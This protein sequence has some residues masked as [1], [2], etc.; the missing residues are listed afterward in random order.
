LAR[1][2]WKPQANEVFAVIRSEAAERLKKAGAVFYEWDAPAGLDL[3][4]DERL[5]RFVTS[6][7]TTQQDVDRFA[8][9]I[10]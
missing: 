4:A 7:A 10:A 6:F 3:A 9:L 2:G 5:F 1:L 8:E